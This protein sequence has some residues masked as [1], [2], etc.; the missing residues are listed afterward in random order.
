MECAV[1]PNSVDVK[2][3]ANSADSFGRDDAVVSK[4]DVSRLNVLV[5]LKPILSRTKMLCCTGV[6]VP[7]VIIPYAH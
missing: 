4:L 7:L 5:I 3:D 2:F 1:P 6:D